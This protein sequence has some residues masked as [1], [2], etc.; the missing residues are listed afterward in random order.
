MTTGSISYDSFI[1]FPTTGG[2]T[3]SK[4]TRS[5]TG[6]DRPLQVYT[7]PMFTYVTRRELGANGSLVKFKTLNP[8]YSNK[9]DENTR[10]P[11]KRARNSTENAY[12][13]NISRLS[14]ELVKTSAPSNFPSGYPVMQFHSVPDWAQ[15]VLLDAN[16]QI[17]LVNKLREK[18]Q[19]SD[20]NMSVFLGEGHQT[21][22]LLADSAIRI[23]KAGYHAKKGDF[24][25]AVRALWEGTTRAP[26]KRRPPNWSQTP[27]DARQVAS[28]WL[29]LQYGWKPLLQDAAGAAEMLA[30]HLEVPARTTYRT[31]VRKEKVNRRLSYSGFNQSGPVNCT[32]VKVHRRSLIARI[33]ECGQTSLPA[34]LGLLD[35]ELVLW[36]LMPFSFI[37]DWFIP[38]GSWMEARA[39]A[40]R[41]KGT[42]VTSDKRQ[43]TCYS[44]VSPFFDHQPRAWYNSTVFNRT[45]STSLK[46]PMPEFKPLSKVASWQHCANAIALVTQVFTGGVQKRFAY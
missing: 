18:L 14:D 17:K 26:L 44:P 4:G 40:G 12:T 1:N 28:N 10:R 37:A 33:E 6:A 36:E 46:V 43:G 20:F 11:V 5:W 29:E 38:I 7:R 22:K 31:S 13:L 32:A 16:D 35:P 9:L 21:L 39:S 30:H 41:L 27:K 34:K 45:I 25:G 23:A 24:P 42:F 2:W 8:A 3:G 15:E 19:G